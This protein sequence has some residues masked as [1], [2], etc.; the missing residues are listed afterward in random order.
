MSKKEKLILPSL[1]G[2]IGDWIYYVTL[3]KFK[4]VAERV[5][6]VPEIH[7]SEGLSNLIQRQVSDRTSDIVEYL[8]TQ[9]QRFFN[10]LILGIY[11]GKPKWHEISVEESILDNL[12]AENEENVKL[13]EVE[14]DQLNSTLG[15][16]ILNGEE[17]IFAIDGQHRTKSIKDAVKGKPE[18]G[19]DEI[20]AIFVAHKKNEEGEIRTRRLFSTINRYAKPVSKNEIIAIDEEDNCAIIT[21]SIVENFELLNG[22]ILFNK[23]KAISTSNSVAFTNII[24]LYD[25]IC[26]IL[27]D[28]KVF[29]IQVKGKEFKNFTHRRASDDILS[30][31]QNFIEELFIQ[32]FNEIPILKSFIEGEVIDRR[33]DTSSLLFRPVGQNILYSVLKV[34]IDKNK[35]DEAITFF[36]RNNFSLANPTWKKIFSDPETDRI[37]TDKT[38]Q[39]YAVQIILKHLGINLRLSDKDKEIH[40][41]FQIDYNTL[42]I[43]EE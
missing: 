21:R 26:T 6:M 15:I 33:L 9:D 36:G 27:T 31:Q 32:I 39:K 42:E 25:F 10:S 43:N 28:N 22:K 23:S 35:R 37:K 30:E 7:K 1:R 16:L 8:K 40:S 18:L 29:G 5:S 19:S 17:K 41:N 12:E 14:V 13:T 20:A 3:L 2:K 11:G 24:V 4:D 38:V 34:A